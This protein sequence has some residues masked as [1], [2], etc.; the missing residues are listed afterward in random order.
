MAE[1]AIP[2]WLPYTFSLLFGFLIVLFVSADTFNRPSYR[3]TERGLYK[4]FSPRDLTSNRLYGR[5]LFLYV[6]VME[7]LF[8]GL[9]FFTDLG[10]LLYQDSETKAIF[11]KLAGTPSY[12]LFA[13]TVVVGLQNA[14]FFKEF[15]SH[16]RANLHKLA[17]IPAGVQGTV[18]ALRRSAFSFDAYVP[19]VKRREPELRTLTVQNLLNIGDTLDR[20]W[21]KVCCVIY[22]LRKARSGQ[23]P[24]DGGFDYSCFDENFFDE[25]AAEYEGIIDL[26]RA[27]AVAYERVRDMEDKGQ[28]S[29]Q[30]LES[31]RQTILD[32]LEKLRERL[33][34]FVACAVRSKKG[35]ESEIVTA[36]NKIGFRLPRI[37]NTP[38]DL[39]SVVYTVGGLGVITYI[40]AEIGP[41]LFAD[42]A[43]E[44][45]RA[46]L[47]YVPKGTSDAAQWLIATFLCH[48]AAA[49]TVLWYRIHLVR[50]NAWENLDAQVARR[51][52][53]KY[54]FGSVLGALAGLAALLAFALLPPVLAY[55]AGAEAVPPEPGTG[56]GTAFM[57]LDMVVQ[58]TLV[59]ALTWIPVFFL[60]ALSILY[61]RDAK[62]AELDWR[63]RI[64]Y[65][66]GHSVISA[67]IG[68]VCARLYTT[69]YADV[70]DTITPAE[71]NDRFHLLMAG[72]FA[73]FGAW[74][75]TIFPARR[76]WMIRNFFDWIGH[77]EAEQRDGSRVGLTLEDDG[78]AVVSLKGEASGD[79]RMISDKI[80]ISVRD[81]DR[82]LLLREGDHVRMLRFPRGQSV[83][84]APSDIW[85]IE[86]RDTT[87]LHGTGYL[88]KEAFPKPVTELSAGPAH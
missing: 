42:V 88:G 7:L 45:W 1:N 4:K 53:L 32:D 19:A 54:L 61:Y 6:L 10:V 16:L 31:T 18:A 70:L 21:S 24:S 28:H 63:H 76:R 48:G 46:V 47:P 55:L 43:T 78:A 17:K 81:G 85:D 27:L 8:V 56:P 84:G 71:V 86:K 60:T 26:H 49:L 25:Y 62:P 69:A 51:P 75:A 83:A 34:N 11:D 20:R 2:N 5:A 77:W 22:C 41:A 80:R 23:V 82:F 66:A 44:D 65:I 14:W 33:Y 35:S 39:I 37:D 67:A 30:D 36:L 74:I 87:T 59:P 57:T 73:L 72:L 52:E 3:K 38:L 29:A 13:A 40:F 12:P 58:R 50:R 15:E 68:F 9:S 64:A 79:W